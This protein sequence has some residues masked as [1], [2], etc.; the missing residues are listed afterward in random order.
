MERQ[1]GILLF[2]K[3]DKTNIDIHWYVDS[4]V[5]QNIIFE[6]ITFENEGL[7]NV[8]LVFGLVIQ[9]YSLGYAAVTDIT[10]RWQHEYNM[11]DNNDEKYLSFI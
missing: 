11:N 4:T 7:S 1:R 10:S 3:L 2:Q 5:K 6:K 9:L 8:D